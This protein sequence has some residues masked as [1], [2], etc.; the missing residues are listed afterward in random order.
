MIKTPDTLHM[1]R[2]VNLALTDDYVLVY[3][4]ATGLWGAEQVDHGALAGLSD[5]DHSNYH[6]NAR[7]DARYLYRENTGA[8][9]PDG[10]YEPAT[11][12]YVDD[13][14]SGAGGGDMTKAVYDTDEDDIVDKAETV[15]D[16]AGN[17]STAAQVKDAVGKAHT[18]NTDTHLGTVDQD[19]SMNSHKLTSVTDP[20]SDQDAATKKYHNDNPVGFSQRVH[21]YLNTTQVLPNQTD[22]RVMLDT[23]DYDTGSDW[24]NRVVSG[25]AD[26]T[27]ANKLHDA[28]G[29]FDAGDVGAWVWNTTDNTYAIVT[30]FVDSGELTLDTNIMANG[31]SYKLYHCVFVAPAE[32]DYIVLHQVRFQNPTADKLVRPGFKVNGSWVAIAYTHCSLTDVAQPFCGRILHLEADDELEAMVWHKCGGNEN[33]VTGTY[34]TWMDIHRIA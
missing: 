3:D 32:G 34:N 9:T 12:K 26:A 25:A 33:I 18:Q 11:K 31:E 22:T 13:S 19:I 21:V 14:V 10:N 28:D 1:L 17:S 30:A 29:G 24:N 2:D 6:T 27:E 4:A 16:G 15:D 5:D 7:G 23:E 20:T 8:F